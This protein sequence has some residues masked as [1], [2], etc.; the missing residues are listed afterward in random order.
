MFEFLLP[1]VSFAIAASVT[2]GPNTIM[3][4]ASG[5]NFGYARTNPHM[6]GITF[7]FPLLIIAI[8]FGLGQVFSRYPQLH[9][10]LKWVGTAYLLFLA[11]KIAT[12]GRSG[13]GE[14]R[15]KPFTFFQAALFQWLNP[16]AWIVAVS[17]LTAFTTV[18][19]NYALETLFIAALF[20]IISY[21]ACA[22]WCLFGTAIRRFLRSDQ[23]LQVFNISMAL[24]GRPSASATTRSREL[25]R[26]TAPSGRDT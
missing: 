16:K 15:G 4:T 17:S 25:H 9:E 23:A 11:W 19:G 18:G 24:I 26:T 14:E 1:I 8:G 12:A 22:V 20:A 13:K 10:I 7:G 5:A 21:P 2:P 6:L 3:V